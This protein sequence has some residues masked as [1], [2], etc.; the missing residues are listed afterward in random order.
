MKTNLSLL[1]YLKKP[2]NYDS[3]EAPIYLR[4]TVNNKRTE[5]ATGRQCDPKLWN[6]HAG[7]VSGSKESVRSLNAYLSNLQEKI[8]DAHSQLVRSGEQVTP[9]SIRNKFLGPIEKPRMLVEIIKDHNKR[10]AALVGSEYAVGTLN[11]YKVLERHTLAFLKIKFG[12][13]DF[14][15]KKIDF[16]FVTDYEFYLRAVR[17]MG[18]NSAVKHMKMFKKILNIGINNNWIQTDPFSNFKGKYK[19]VEKAVLTQ[20]EIETLAGKKFV[21][22]RLAQVRDTFLFCCYTG[23]AYSDVQ[24][25]GASD[26]SEGFDGE[27]WITIRRVKTNQECNIPLLPEAR[28]I[29]E[30]YSNHRICLSKGNLLPVASNQK[31]NDYLKE[32]AVVCGINKPM[33]CH[34]ARHTFA[35]TITLQN[36]VPIE[37][38][39]RMLGHT[40]IRTTQIYAKILN[41]KV[42]RDMLLLK[43]KLAKSGDGSSLNLAKG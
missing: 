5:I 31:M 34:V 22:E 42:S 9:E 18:N 41:I 19:K 3:G 6:T 16:A 43:D 27:H 25:L 36:G 21:S 26:I 23:L 37:T 13:S 1:F 30:R 28:K 7:R 39:S 14:D 33:T 2:K 12:T 29:I 20:A 38:V 4:V 15:I 8:F 32:I 11:R 24:K 35:T 40:D 10:M 17:K